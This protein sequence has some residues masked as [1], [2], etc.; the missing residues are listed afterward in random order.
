MGDRRWRERSNVRYR[1]AHGAHTRSMVGIA[2]QVGQRGSITGTRDRRTEGGHGGPCGRT[3]EGG[4]GD[5]SVFISSR[6]VGATQHA[7]R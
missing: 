5:P 3:G 1:T 2:G 6:S 7:Y 4:H